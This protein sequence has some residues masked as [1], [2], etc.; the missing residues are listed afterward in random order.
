MNTVQS[1]PLGVVRVDLGPRNQAEWSRLF[2]CQGCDKSLD[3]NAEVFG[4]YRRH[5]ARMGILEWSS[6]CSV[7]GTKDG[8]TDFVRASRVNGPVIQLNRRNLILKPSGENPLIA[9][10]SKFWFT[11]SMRLGIERIN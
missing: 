6:C 8:G 3:Q 1:K 2:R 5:N 4:E 10:I 9:R 7:C 11:M